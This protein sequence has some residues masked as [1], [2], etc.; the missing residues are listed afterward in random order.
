M[1]NIFVTFKL[2]AVAMTAKLSERFDIKSQKGVTIIEY[3][4]LGA[5][6]AAALVASLTTLKTNIAT[7]FTTIGTAISA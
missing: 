4:L 7:L 5:L 1:S 2:I 3:A 6:I